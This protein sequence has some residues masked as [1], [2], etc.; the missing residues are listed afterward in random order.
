[1]PVSNG[2]GHGDTILPQGSCGRRLRRL[3]SDEFK[4]NTVAAAAQPGVSM[5]AAAMSE[6]EVAC[7]SM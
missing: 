7:E 3:H 1:M 6:A 5:D 2:C 4:A